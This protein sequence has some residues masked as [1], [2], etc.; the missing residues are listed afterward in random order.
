MKK[1]I[2]GLIFGLGF[3]AYG[4]TD[5]DVFNASKL[6]HGGSARFQAMGGA[7]GAMG[8]DVS[9]NQINPAAYGRYSASVF[10][11][12]A[13][14]NINVTTSNFMDN[15]NRADRTRFTVPNV[16]IV[17]T[18][19]LSHKNKGDMFSQIGIG[20]NR[21]TNF[22]QNITIAGIQGPSLLDNFAGQAYG[23][24]PG[25]LFTYFPFSTALAYETW[26]INFDPS[27]GGYQS[28]LTPTSV[29]NMNRTYQ[30][31]GGVN[32]FTFNY[33]RNRMNKLYWGFNINVRDYKN[34]QR[35]KHTETLVNEPNN[36]FKSFDYDYS[37]RTTGS[38]VSAKLGVIY[39]VTNSLRIG[40]SFHTPT[41]L[42]LRDNW[43]ADMTTTFQDSIKYIRS[44][45]VPVGNYK[46][47]MLTP[48]KLN[49]SVAYTIGTK[50][51]IS[52]DI[53]YIAYT[54]GRLRP[55]FDPNY[56]GYNFYNENQAVKE[57]LTHG[58]NFRIG[59]EYVIIQRF[60]VRAG[61]SLYGSAYKK[62]EN[63]DPRPDLSYS[64]G[65]G[66]KKGRVSI[67]LAYVNRVMN[68]TNFL[69]NGSN[70]ATTRFSANQVIASLNVY[71]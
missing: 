1:L 28:L 9:A 11:I 24:N 22:N 46:Y 13:G 35:Y 59:G 3:T 16:N 23:V 66:Y 52:T 67:D 4:Q 58:V 64:G 8:A 50:A 40:G 15:V 62:I 38:G 60:F 39:L 32:E 25:E 47:R 54:T 30:K 26:A 63:V 34:I 56:A 41:L 27:T 51:T 21:I 2:I 42:S 70:P 57:R 17:L 55:P 65:L 71:F 12:T 68:R 20:Y 36:A 7:M 43:T 33:S 31:S 19:D 53:E 10:G 45:L 37:L 6:Y 69:Y 48:L 5:E 18:Q 49:A 44:D 61:F 29:V 14:A